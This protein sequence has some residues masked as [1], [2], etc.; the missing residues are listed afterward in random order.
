MPNIS[1]LFVDII[2]VV[3]VYEIILHVDEF[4]ALRVG[5]KTFKQL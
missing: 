2:S 3:F 5:S 1:K 4:E